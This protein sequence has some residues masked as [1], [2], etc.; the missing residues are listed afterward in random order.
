MDDLLK[1]AADAGHEIS[2]A[3]AALDEGAHDAARDALDRA[4]DHLADLRGRWA[5]MSAPQRAVVGPAAKAVRERLDAAAARVPARRTLSEAPAEVD[6][7][8]EAEP[9]LAGGASAPPA[10]EPP[11]AA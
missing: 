9:E 7:E 3:E 5:G 1:L 6:P 10:P 8:Q 11:A 2:T 4:A